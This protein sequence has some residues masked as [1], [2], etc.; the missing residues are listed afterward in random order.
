MGNFSISLPGCPVAVLMESSQLQLRDS[1]GVGTTV[2]HPTSFEVYPYTLAQL[3]NFVKPKK[4]E[5]HGGTE[6][7]EITGE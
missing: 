7:T 3:E 6:G 5:S 4:E 2:P 1:G